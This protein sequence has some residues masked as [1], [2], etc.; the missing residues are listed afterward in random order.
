MER[1]F[2]YPAGKSVILF[3]LPDRALSGLRL[4]RPGR[5]PSEQMIANIRFFDW[6]FITV[7]V[8]I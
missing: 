3:I 1:I 2:P 5:Q 4:G 6:T 7:R 8:S